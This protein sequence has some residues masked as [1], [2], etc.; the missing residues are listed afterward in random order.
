MF[1]LGA[2]LVY[3]LYNK[4]C[5][6]RKSFDGLSGLVSQE[7][8]RNPLSGEVF[9]FLNRHKNLIK[10]LHWQDGGFVLYY[11]RLEI[12]TFTPP[13]MQPDKT[14]IKWSELVLMIEG[15][16]VKEYV[17]KKRYQVENKQGLD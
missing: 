14:Q 11:K 10:L 3:Q 8:G 6:L 13:V 15:I 4:P 7:L 16:Q 17:A 9:I 1:S 2:S 12:G 5:D